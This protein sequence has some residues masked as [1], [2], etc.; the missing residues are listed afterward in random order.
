MKLLKEQ[1]SAHDI[2]TELLLTLPSVEQSVESNAPDEHNAARKKLAILVSY[3]KEQDHFIN[4]SVKR[5]SATN[6]F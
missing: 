4:S 1:I 5:I 3:P 6:P 2:L